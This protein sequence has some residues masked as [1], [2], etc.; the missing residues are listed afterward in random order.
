[1]GKVRL[2]QRPSQVEYSDFEL[3]KKK[4]DMHHIVL[5]QKNNSKN[6]LE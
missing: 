5:D 4:I 1:M 2:G 3:F 6:I